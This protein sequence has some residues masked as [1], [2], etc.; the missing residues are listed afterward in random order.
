[1]NSIWRTLI[2]VFSSLKL[3]CS[4]LMLL[5]LLTWL[6]TLE[7]VDTG[8]FEVQKK[9][10]ESFVLL[11]DVGPF[12]I[13]LPGANLVMCVLFVN[14]LV[15]G[16][17]RLRKSGGTVGILITHIGIL[18]LLVSAFVKAYYA[19]DG[20]VT[21]FEGQRSGE[22]Q[23]YYRWEIAI[24]E[25]L[26]D[27]RVRERIAPEELFHDATG[28]ESIRL[29]APELPFVL[30]VHHLMANCQALPKGPM[31]E[32]DVPV[33]DG[34]F[35]QRQEK[36][37]EAEENI[38]GC[39]VSAVPRDGSERRAGILWGVQT[40]PLTVQVGGKDY[41]IDLRRERYPMPFTLV[42]DDFRKEDHPRMSMARAFESDVTVVEGSSARPIKIS[43]NQPL[44]E[45]GL[46]VYQSGW[47]PQNAP[48]GAPLFSTF[49]V[50]RNPADQFPL[51]SCLVIA[52][53][54]LLHFGRKLARYIRAEAHAT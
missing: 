45:G 44:R 33:I 42:L 14:L 22:Y 29:D 1:M 30:E 53:G 38:A 11:H 34:V 40:G 54:M 48:P 15:G 6:G 7:Q 23:S 25:P 32:V 24:Q 41:G 31:F 51:Y 39:Y 28:A 19:T 8:L 26:G 16:V 37:R 49:S 36:S 50:V 3:S 35:L 17:V 21:L 20:H 27:G 46:V 12:K 2:G 18:L 13:P 52:A 10:F 5:A 43:M 9:Y 47:G 4:L